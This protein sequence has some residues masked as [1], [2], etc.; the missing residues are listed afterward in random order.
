MIDKEA[1]TLLSKAEAISAANTAVNDA[2]GAE[3]P[4]PLPND[5]TLHDTEGYRENR[6]RARGTMTTSVVAHFAAYTNVYADAGAAVFIDPDRMAATAV[7][8]LGTQ[9]F[10]GH[11][12]NLAVIALRQTAPFVALLQKATGMALKQADVAEFI[13]DW[14]HLIECSNVDGPIEL[15][16]A[17]AAVRRITIETLKK[18]EASE[19]LLSASKSAFESVEAKSADP[20]PTAL[21]FTCDPYQGLKPRTIR[22]RLGVLTTGDKPS[23]VLRVINLEQHKEDMADELSQLVADAFTEKLP[24]HIGTYTKR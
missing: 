13:E 23:I 7:L 9:D 4:V 8:N 11:A 15:R 3:H 18:A 12:D 10:P 22:V 6:R 2:I 20:I 14:G 21:E 17:I 24:V 16:K 5:Y 19:Q 1:I